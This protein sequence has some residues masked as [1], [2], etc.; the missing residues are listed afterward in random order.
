MPPQPV[1]DPE[2][3]KLYG[4]KMNYRYGQQIGSWN[5]YVY[6]ITRTNEDGVVTELSW[7]QVKGRCKELG[8]EHVPEMAGDPTP[9]VVGENTPLGD[10]GLMADAILEGPSHLD[11][12]HIREGICLRI[13][14]PDGKIWFAKHKSFTFK[15]LEG[16]IKDNENYVDREEIA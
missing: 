2:V 13:E 8:I 6:R 4:D 11:P 1:K 9:I 12:T 5:I 16:I 7:P 15:V 10:V 3:R 14:Q